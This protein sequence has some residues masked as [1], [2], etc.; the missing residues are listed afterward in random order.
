MAEEP[1]NNTDNPFSDT[2]QKMK[3][4]STQGELKTNEKITSKDVE[5]KDDEIVKD[6]SEKDGT[7]T[8]AP[9]IDDA[10]QLNSDDYTQTPID[11]KDAATYDAD[12]SASKKTKD[13]EFDAAKGKVSEGAIMDAAQGQLSPEAMAKADVADLDPRATGKYQ[14]EQLFS[15]IE[16]GKPPPPWLSPAMRKVNSIMNARGLGGSSMAAAAQ[17]MAAME[18]GVP[19]ALNDAKAYATLQLANQSAKNQAILQN[20]AAVAAMDTKNLDNRQMANVNN[21]KAF[22]TI[23]VQNLTNEQAT[24]TL[25]YQSLMTAILSDQKANNTAKQINTKTQNEL[26]KFYDE[27]GVQV[28]TLTL[29]RALAADQ[30]NI[31]QDTAMRQFAAQLQTQNDQFNATNQIQINQSNAVWRRNVNT[32]NTAAQ[33]ETNRQ[34]VMNLLNINQNALNNIWQSY[35]DYASWNVQISESAKDRAH[36]AAMQASQ[37]SNNMAMYNQK[38]D[39]FLIMKTIDNFFT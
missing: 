35:R 32:I 24:N 29:N 33:N 27:L 25:K 13:A 16:E 15:T 34:N 1:E 22:L 2:V 4:K 10:K 39:D 7:K 18:A 26:M 36:N 23:D 38:F 20:A 5:I 21:A 12:T 37:I 6:V 3:D 9:N 17:V 14:L 19:I 30:Y 11:P 8:T 28:E 31:S